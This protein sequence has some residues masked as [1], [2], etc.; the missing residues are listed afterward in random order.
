MRDVNATESRYVLDRT[1]VAVNFRIFE[2][3]RGGTT[4]DPIFTFD[5]GSQMYFIVRETESG[6]YGIDCKIKLP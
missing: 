1:I 5:D 4:T 6:T 2:D 3:G